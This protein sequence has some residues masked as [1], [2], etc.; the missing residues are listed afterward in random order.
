MSSTVDN[1][2]VK[3][4]S[5]SAWKKAA[6][7]TIRVPSGEFIEV[8]IP[9]LPAM[10]EGGQIP[11][12][13]LDAALSAASGKDQQHPTVELI[14]QQKEFTDH[15]V[16]VTVVTPT[17]SD[18]DL[19]DIPYEDKELIVEIAMR[20]RDL[21]AEGSHIAGLDTSEKFRRFRGLSSGDPL[22][23]D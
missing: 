3:P 17:L 20:Q 7:H 19:S 12:N 2:G 11:Q 21:D 13:L 14:K 22:L 4:A 18:A 15:L 6:V 9:D 23:D 1:A 8:K 5:L 16:K 10:I